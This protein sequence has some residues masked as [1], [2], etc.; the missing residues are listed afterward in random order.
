MESISCWSYVEEVR[1]CVAMDSN[2]GK[3]WCRLVEDFLV[4]CRTS[5]CVSVDHCSRCCWVYHAL[6]MSHI[7]FGRIVPGC[8]RRHNTLCCITIPMINIRPTGSHSCQYLDTG[9]I[10]IFIFKLQAECGSLSFY[11]LFL[12][13]NFFYLFIS[14]VFGE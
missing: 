13:L 12:F 4:K 6:F 1:C 8:K 5:L 7:E 3:W 9:V 14:N 11:F 2:L 10:F